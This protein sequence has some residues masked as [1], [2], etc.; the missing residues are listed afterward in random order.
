MEAALIESFITSIEKYQG[1][2]NAN[3]DEYELLQARDVRD[4]ANLIAD[5][6]GTTKAGLQTYKSEL[7]ADGLADIVMMAPTLHRSSHGFAAPG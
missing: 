6:L 7:A 4:F 1:A 3:D 2:D 5:Q